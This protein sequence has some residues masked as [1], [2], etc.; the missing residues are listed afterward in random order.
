L[1]KTAKFLTQGDVAAEH[2]I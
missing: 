2:Q 1:T